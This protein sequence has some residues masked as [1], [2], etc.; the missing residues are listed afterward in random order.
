MIKEFLVMTL[1]GLAIAAVSAAYFTAPSGPQIDV[2]AQR[3]V[4]TVPQALVEALACKS[5]PKSCINKKSKVTSTSAFGGSS[6]ML[7]EIRLRNDGSDVA[8]SV[9]IAVEDD[10]VLFLKRRDDFES[11]KSESGRAEISLMPGEQNSLFV[12]DSKS[13]NTLREFPLLIN[14][15]IHRY[16]DDFKR[17][18]LNTFQKFAVNFSVITAFAYFLAVVMLIVF[19]FMAVEG[20]YK[21]NNIARA[22]E[23]AA[24]GELSEKYAY[25]SILKWND[26]KRFDILVSKAEYILER[27]GWT[28]L[29]GESD[30]ST[31]T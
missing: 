30:S 2:K 27:A 15:R 17:D 12:A 23:R 21:R 26:R 20:V 10:D 3:L 14:D 28:R 7:Y 19:I 25:M 11:L 8:K 4:M 18:G 24:D 9:R 16:E 31:S 6:A 13:K 29:D 5:T 22:A 1:S